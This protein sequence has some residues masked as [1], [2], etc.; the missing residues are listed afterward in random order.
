MTRPPSCGAT[1]IVA[2]DGPGG[3]GK[4]TFAARLA[5]AL[6]TVPIIHTDD[7]AGWENQFDW[8]DRLVTQVLE[9][10]AVGQPGRY[11]RYDWVTRSF[12]EWHDV[13]IAPALVIEGVGA[14][15]REFVKR[16]SFVVWIETPAALRLARG[17]ERDGEALRAFWTQWV[18]GENRHFTADRTRDRT[19]LVVSGNPSAPHDPNT[20]FV[21]AS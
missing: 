12:A 19:E 21:V 18:D 7:F 5:Q 10:L 1:R 17:I 20:E 6:G 4:S 16:L 14:A 2:I 11:Q 3:A 13:P 8:A 9:P 15:R